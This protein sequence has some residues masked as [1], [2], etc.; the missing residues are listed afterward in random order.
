MKLLFLS[1][2]QVI[3]INSLSA[4]ENPSPYS[5]PKKDFSQLNKNKPE[6]DLDYEKA[7]TQSYNEYILSLKST[8]IEEKNNAKN[9]SLSGNNMPIKKLKSNDNMVIIKPDST[10]NYHILQMEFKTNKQPVLPR[11]EK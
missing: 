11:E 9:Q 4:Q 2:L 6:F 3:L 5:T 1:F 10:I 7:I 8:E